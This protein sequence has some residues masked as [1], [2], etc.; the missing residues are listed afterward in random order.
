MKSE[1]ISC[2]IYYLSIIVVEDI[3]VSYLKYEL[4]LVL[5]VI[6][7]CP[8]WFGGGHLDDHTAHTPHVTLPA[9]PTSRAILS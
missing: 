8:G 9:I 7:P 6:G 2:D 3:R 4:V 1:I 5:D